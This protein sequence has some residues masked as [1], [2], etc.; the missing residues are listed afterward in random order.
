MFS[1]RMR[2][3]KRVGRE[4]NS[5]VS[6]DYTSTCIIMSFSPEIRTILSGRISVCVS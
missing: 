2:K 5:G 6:T 1:R 4:L 3:R